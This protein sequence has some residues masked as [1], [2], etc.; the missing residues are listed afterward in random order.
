MS[1]DPNSHAGGHF[2]VTG[3]TLRQDARCYVER[4]AD[5]ELREALRRGEFCYV[6]TSRQMGKSSLMVRTAAAL[7]QKGCETVVLDLTAIGLNVTP[8]QWYDGLV[9]RLGNQLRLEDEVEAYWEA[10]R[11]RGPLQRFMGALADVVVPK[12]S[13]R[14]AAKGKLNSSESW[15]VIFVDEIDIVRSLPFSTDEFFAGILEFYNRRAS[16]ESGHGLTFCLLGAATPADLIRD[17]RITPFNIGQRIE[18]TDFSP[19]EARALVPGLLRSPWFLQ[20]QAEYLGDGGGM[21]ASANAMLERVLEWTEGH[22][23]LTQR[24]CRSL[25]EPDGPVISLDSVE[26]FVDYWVQELFLSTAARDK[27]DNLIYVR[28]RILR[29]QRDLSALFDLYHRI[30][31]GESVENEESNALLDELRLSG[32]IKSEERSVRVRNQIYLRIFDVDWVQA[33]RPEA[34]LVRD[35]GEQIPLRGLC[36]LGRVAANDVVLNSDRVSRRHAQVQLHGAN[37]FWLVDLGS[38]NGTFLNGRRVTQTVC[39]QDQDLIE[40]GGIA[41]QFRQKNGPKREMD[42]RNATATDVED[43]TVIR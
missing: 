32:V 28:E 9:A 15:L 36:N 35:S 30:L 1:T 25:V 24:L 31:V 26:A 27:D 18:L 10:N 2:F 11:S 5:R 21:R 34:F 17:P 23:Y 39:L 19:D 7:R 38:R 16:E 22:P 4:K 12:I 43:M 40:I 33:S 3:G 29:T 41:L 8:E 20:G 37:E 42:R 6:L 14:A 13:H